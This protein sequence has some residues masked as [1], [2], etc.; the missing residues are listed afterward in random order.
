[1]ESLVELGASQLLQRGVD[2]TTVHRTAGDQF[3]Q[4]L[5]FGFALGG[6]GGADFGDLLERNCQQPI[7]VTDDEVTGFDHH[8]VDS[9]RASDLPG[10]RPHRTPMGDASGIDRKLLPT[11]RAGIPYRSVD[12]DAAETTPSR[13]CD[14]DL[15][16]DRI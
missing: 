2:P 1:P 8:A 16:D 7:G 9:N 14:H 13:V 11:D 4:D 5:A 12:H 15:A 6:C 10:T 3:V